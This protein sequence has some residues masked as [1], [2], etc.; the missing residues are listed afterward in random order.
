MP[1]PPDEMSDGKPTGHR[2]EPWP[3]PWDPAAAAGP[4]L[5]RPAPGTAGHPDR[6]ATAHR[7]LAHAAVPVPVPG[8]FTVSAEGV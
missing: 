8:A 5:G 3:T 6:W 1:M 7:F 4:Q 2:R